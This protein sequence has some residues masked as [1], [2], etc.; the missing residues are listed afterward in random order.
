MT[1]NTTQ[2]AG[3]L[4]RLT[5]ELEAVF[6]KDILELLETRLTNKGNA[7]VVNLRLND[8]V[9]KSLVDKAI[10]KLKEKITTNE[11]PNALEFIGVL[12]L[13]HSAYLR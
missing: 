13:M 7:E 6:D 5:A 3:C 12:A 4:S 2:A 10:S 8:F 1:E 11:E 9:K